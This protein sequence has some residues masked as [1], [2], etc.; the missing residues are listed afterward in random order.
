MSEPFD[1]RQPAHVERVASWLAGEPIVRLIVILR[2][3]GCGYAR[4]PTGGCTMCG[5]SALTSGGEPVATADLVA[6]VEAVLADPVR[7][8]GVAEVDLYNSGSFFADDEIPAAARSAMLA[9]L[10]GL[11]LRR[12]LVE[13]RPEHLTPE[14]LEAARAALGETELEVG[15]GLESADDR[16]REVLVRKGFSRPQF[17]RAAALLGRAG[18]RLLAYVVLKPPGLAEQEAI[19]D[20]VRT[21]SWVHATGR[22]H[23]VPTR[24]ALEPIFV[25]A[26]TALER[27]FLAGRYQP[28]S[29]WSVAEVV[30][31]AHLFGEIL[32]GL[33][34]EGLAAGRIPAGCP[35]CTSMLRQALG[36]YNRE[37]RVELLVG[38]VCPDCHPRPV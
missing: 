24:A 29:L 35:R 18:A 7:L 25:P 8:A 2:A 10:G 4:G 16:V 34:D 13:S 32:V 15:I 6:Q 28:P 36:R 38:L 20:A 19:E 30:R 31:R 17:E 9:R 23:K 14:K 5:F 11:G 3:V 22:Q 33:S 12:V 37:R 1:P 27:E 26:G 21:I